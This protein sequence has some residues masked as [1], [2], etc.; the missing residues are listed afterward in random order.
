MK[1]GGCLCRSDSGMT[2]FAAGQC[3]DGLLVVEPAVG[4]E[5]VTSASEHELIESDKDASSSVVILS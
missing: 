4:I 3:A 5:S 1:S 2:L